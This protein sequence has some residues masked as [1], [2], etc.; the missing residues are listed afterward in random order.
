MKNKLYLL[1][2]FSICYVQSYAQTSDQKCVIERFTGAWVG[3]EPDASVILE[4][5]LQTYPNA[6]PVAVHYDDDLQITDGVILQN[7]YTS[8][9]PRAT[10]NRLD[11]AITRENWETEVDAVLSG[12]S[13]ATVSFDS[14]WYQP[15]TRQLDVIVKVDFT[16]NESGAMRLNC[17]VVED[18]VNGSG[19]GYNQVNYDNGTVGHPYYAAGNPIINYTHRFVARAYLGGAWGTPGIIPTSV[20][21][22]NS[23]QYHYT[24]IIP[25]EFDENQISLVGIVSKFDGSSVTSRYI[26][27]AETFDIDNAVINDLS[28]E[29]EKVVDFILFP[30]PCNTFLTVRLNELTTVQEMTIFSADGKLVLSISIEP[31]S[32]LEFTFSIHDLEPGSYIIRC[33]SAFRHFIKVHK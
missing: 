28:I 10:M 6:I 2:A 30:N 17:I 9:Y 15:S 24:Y 23:Y 12:V 11:A 19:F 16:G 21:A 29:N 1:V 3:W 25:A 7:F 22:G 14:V 32:N 4:D 27:N 31:D 20:S 18:S 33:G 13:S 26:I 8:G 5:I